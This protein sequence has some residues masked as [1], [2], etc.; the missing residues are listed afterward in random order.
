MTRPSVVQS[1]ASGT[2]WR[3]G[4]ERGGREE[5]SPDMV[6]LN[7]GEDGENQCYGVTVL[8]CYSVTV[9]QCY[10]VTVLQ[11]YSVT[12][13]QRVGV[14]YFSNRSLNPFTT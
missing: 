1:T 4:L 10:S 3:D 6:P 9:L 11:C 14:I 2:S 8:Q 7:P 12:V 5:V 13:L